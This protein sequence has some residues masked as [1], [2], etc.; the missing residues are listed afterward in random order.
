MK[1]VA[2]LRYQLIVSGGRAHALERGIERVPDRM[3]LR[4]ARHRG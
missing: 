4:I 3:K 2:V 1:K